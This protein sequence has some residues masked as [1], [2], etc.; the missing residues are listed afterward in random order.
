RSIPF[1]RRL[2]S[3]CR[4]RSSWR[5]ATVATRPTSP[6]P[7][8]GTPA[9][10]SPTPTTDSPSRPSTAA[11]RACSSRTS[12]SGNLRSGCAGCASWRPIRRDSGSRTAITSAAIPGRKSAMTAIEWRVAT[13]AELVE[14]TASAR[15]LVLS[16]PD[17]PGHRPG[18]HVDV[19]LTSEDGYQAQRSY[20]IA[21]P[22]ARS[23]IV[24]TIER[25]DDGEV[26]PFLTEDMRPG[27]ALELRGP[28][29]GYFTWTV[30]AGHPLQLIGG[31][32]GIFPL[33]SILPPLPP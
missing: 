13:V 6:S 16:V 17:W 20:S 22:P 30:G 28:I 8:C 14:E 4:P 27:D 11:R 21:S 3:R 23:E 32:S 26:S 33:L 9:R 19:R 5:R 15:S 18:Q 24:L 2:A 10:S 7:I 1:L 31:A 29:G 25:I 12:T